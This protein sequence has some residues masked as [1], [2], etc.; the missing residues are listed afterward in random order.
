MDD[1]VS[2]HLLHCNDNITSE[3]Q[4]I[5]EDGEMKVYKMELEVDGITVDPIKAVHTVKVYMPCGASW[6][7]C[8]IMRCGGL[9]IMT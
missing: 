7:V 3:W 9:V 5:A 4:L 8:W 6:V 1:H 2:E